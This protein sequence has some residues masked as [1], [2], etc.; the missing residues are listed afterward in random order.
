MTLDDYKEEQK[1]AYR[2]LKNALKKDKCSHAYLLESN[3]Y[4][5]SLDFAISFAKALLCPHNLTSDKSCSNCNQCKV[6]SDNNFIEL[7]IISPDGEWIK[8]EQLDDLQTLFSKKAIIGNKKVY[9]I[10]GV[11]KLNTSSANSILKFLE[12][13]EVGIYAILVTNN[14]NSV[15]STISSRCQIISLKKGLLSYNDCEDNLLFKIANSIFNSEEKIK[16]FVEDESSLNIVNSVINFINYYEENHLDTFFELNYLWNKT[17]NEREDISIAFMIMILFYKD[18]LNYKLNYDL[19]IFN[20]Y[21]DDI[22]KISIKSKTNDII[23][24]INIILD[25]QEKIK[26]NLNINLIMDKLLLSFE[27]CV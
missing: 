23:R 17:I 6:I 9:I 15:I 7:K 1:V 12:E 19:Q 4:S 26:Y 16:K 18:V 20:K 13:P 22:K 25:L 5:K 2:I 11:E 21:K 24:K 3:G 27:G 8:K 10:D 14:I